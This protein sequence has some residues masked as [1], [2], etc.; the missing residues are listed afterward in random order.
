VI[1]VSARRWLLAIRQILPA[2]LELG[3]DLIDHD[4]FRSGPAECGI[5][6]LQLVG[7]AFRGDADQSNARFLANG[8]QRR[9]SASAV[10][11][12]S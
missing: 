11:H 3:E 6:P 2:A 4:S 1:A 5:Q 12:Q 7:C 9:A 10:S 8:G